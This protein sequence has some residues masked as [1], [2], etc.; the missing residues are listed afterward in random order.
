MARVGILAFGSLIW[1]P[2]SDLDAIVVDR[3]SNVRTP[4]KVEFARK[5]KSRG[6]GPTL[7]RVEEGG[8]EVKGMIL[9]LKDDITVEEATEVVKNRERGAR[10]S[11]LHD[12]SGI[13]VVLYADPQPNIEN[14]SPKVLADLAMDSVRF[15]DAG[16]DGI[17]YLIKAKE[18]GIVTPLR[19]DYEEEILMRT[20]ARNLGTA[21][22]RLL[23]R[24]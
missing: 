24:S 14:L 8:A 9:V 1:A 6:Y 19:T 5:S 20:S 21:R 7:V 23:R 13:E 22:E 3:I 18:A 4:F 2:E 16:R 15:A 12:F 17:T 11:R 10:V